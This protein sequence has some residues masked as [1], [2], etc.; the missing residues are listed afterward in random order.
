MSL[1]KGFALNLKF[2]FIA[3]MS[4][5]FEPSSSDNLGKNHNNVE[6]ADIPSMYKKKD[7]TRSYFCYLCY[8]CTFFTYQ[9]M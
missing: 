8:F 1:K 7:I 2:S 5:F 4:S 3:Q 9:I 6:N